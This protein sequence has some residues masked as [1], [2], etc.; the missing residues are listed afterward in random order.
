MPT[1]HSPR[2]GRR[3][4]PSAGPVLF[5]GQLRARLAATS[6]DE[7]AFLAADP[8]PYRCDRLLELGADL[9]DALIAYALPDGS[10][11]RVGESAVRM[12][13]LGVAAEAGRIW[14]ATCGRPGRED[15]GTWRWP[16]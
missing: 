3:R 2:R 16:E 13:A 6:A 7:L 5:A 11:G 8:P 4:V 1:H 9:A 10:S 14:T 12:A 15:G